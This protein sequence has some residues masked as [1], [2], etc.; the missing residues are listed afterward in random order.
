MTDVRPDGEDVTRIL[1]A[2]DAG[3]PEAGDRLVSTLYDELRRVARAQMAR[4]R[5]GHTLQATALVHEA[6]VRLFAGQ[7]PR[8]ENR[9]HFFGAAAEA[10]RRIL[11]E[12]A[13][14]HARLKRGGDHQRVSLGDLVDEKG[15][16]DPEQLLA[17][18]IVLERLQAT[19]P[20]MA[21]VAKLRYF[22]GLT[23]EETAEALGVA[24]RTVNRLW[25][26]ARAWIHRELTR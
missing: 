10:M 21:Q 14:R 6:Y 17:L 22:S 13:R 11:V 4:E 23:V 25:L 8:F 9:A 2:I 16:V 1:Q 24:P 5:P 7:S 15:S 20:T 26:A 19:D 12:R 18:D 3:D